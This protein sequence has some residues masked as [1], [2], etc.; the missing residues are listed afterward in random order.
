M[1]GPRSVGERA[2]LLETERPAAVASWV[3]AAAAERR[4]PVLDVVPAARTVL[5]TA[6]SIAACA[7][8]RELL[9]AL[10]DDLS[11]S[12]TIGPLVSITVRFDGADLPAVAE[13]AGVHTD[14]VV[15]LLLATE[16]VV[17]FCGFAPGFA[18]LGGLP[19]AL[20]LPRRAEPRVRV[21]AGSL[22]VADE[23]AAIY[24]RVSP[25]GWHLV[26]T[27]NRVLFDVDRDP[28]ALL[29]AGTRVRFEAQ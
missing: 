25:G 27:T 3:R 24:P 14:E 19:D 11:G 18:Y 2:L 21:P 13:R 10:P 29:V 6:A 4:V 28:P 7:D 5:V 23:Y 8:I 16:F 17:R 15:R 9:A 12:E 1:P 20:R 22:A 26:G